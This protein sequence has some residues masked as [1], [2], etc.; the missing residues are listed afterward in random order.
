ML[1]IQDF[2][3][4]VRAYRVDF[5]KRGFFR[6]E[7]GFESAWVQID[8]VACEILALEAKC[9]E[10]IGLANMFDF[11]ELVEDVSKN[12]STTKQE[13][14]MVKDVWDTSCLCELQFQVRGR[15]LSMP[16]SRSL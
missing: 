11:P 12:I 1:E 14:I 2:N 10:F 4:R 15:T 6:Y 7:I 13:L 3:L 5:F 16:S 9:N 8:E